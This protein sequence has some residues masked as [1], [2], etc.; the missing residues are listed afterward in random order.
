MD[1]ARGTR[2][3]SLFTLTQCGKRPRF[4][5]SALARVALE[6]ARCRLSAA[7]PAARL[8][9]GLLRAQRL[10]VE[11]DGGYHARRVSADARRDRKLERGGY[12]VLR[13]EAELVMRGIPAA[14][15][16]VRRA[17]SEP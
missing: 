15:L 8:Y 7:S 13:L 17:L 6:P 14:A 9:R 12:R 16:A 1:S 2:T 3:P 11:V 5:G 4:R 10:I